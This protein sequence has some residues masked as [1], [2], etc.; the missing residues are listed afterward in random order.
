M[1]QVEERGCILCY[2]AGRVQGVFFRASAEEQAGQLGIEGYAKNC[3]DG[4]VEVLACG[5]QTAL[6][7]LRDW[8]RRGP[9]AAEVVSVE[10]KSIEVDGGRGF[11]IL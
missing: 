9:P 5:P 4:R 6:N 10:C 11:R 3:A 8:L 1:T 2:A 7:A